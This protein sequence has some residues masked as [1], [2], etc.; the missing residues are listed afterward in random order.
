MI[1]GGGPAGAAAAITLA[2]RGTRSLVLERDSTSQHKVCG[3]FLSEEALRY[4]HRLG[5]DAAFLGA[6][7]I[8]AVRLADGRKVREAALPFAAMSLTRKALDAAL[9]AR[10]E[11]LGATVCRG[12]AVQALTETQQ[13]WHAQAADQRSFFA[14]AAMLATGKHDL[15]GYPRPPGRQPGLLAFKMYWRLSAAQSVALTEHVELV[16]YNG[17]YAG[18]Q[19]IEGGMANLCCLVTHREYKRLGARWET[20]LAAMCAQSPH[21]ATRLQGA[22]PLLDR[23]LAISSIPYGFVRAGSN[24]LWCLGDQA[25]VIPSFTGDGM[26]I[27]LHT[28]VLAAE[29]LNAGFPA[30]MFQQRLAAQVRAQV[31]IATSLS[32]AMIGRPR[33]AMLAARL[34]PGVLASIARH[35]RIAPGNL[36]A[37]ASF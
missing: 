17:G 31:T 12:T 14:A 7:P 16:L 6:V 35:T 10:A 23:P 37:N 15:R 4:L 2:Q 1:V 11:S 26:S 22:E 9:L 29:M 18:L 27:A 20:F 5:L 30:Q 25:A 24:S 19:P 21:L 34:W 8:R 28:G 13:G 32:Q 36:L 3:E 33:L